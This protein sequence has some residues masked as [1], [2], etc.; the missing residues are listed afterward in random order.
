MDNALYVGRFR[1]FHKGYLQTVKHILNQRHSTLIIAIGAAEQSHRLDNPF[2]GRERARM[3]ASALIEEGLH[4]H[5]HI[6]QIDE[7]S[8][9]YGKWARYVETM[10]PPFQLV[11]SHSELVRSLFQRLGYQTR[12]VPV[13]TN[14]EYSFDLVTRRILSAQPWEHLIPTGVTRMIKE[15]QL[16][17]RIRDM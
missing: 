8:V 16:L 1:V 4:Q 13:F 12:A 3:V 10:C 2:S 9:D 6:V 15:A 17:Q 5:V 11:Y 14:P 7:T